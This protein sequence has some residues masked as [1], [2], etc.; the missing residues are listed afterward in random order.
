MIQV[1]HVAYRLLT[2]LDALSELLA[3]MNQLGIE[4]KK[5]P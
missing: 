1:V 2:F 4:L 5:T 3:F